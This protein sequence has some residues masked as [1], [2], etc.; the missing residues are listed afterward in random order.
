MVGDGLGQGV[1]GRVRGAAIKFIGSSALTAG[2]DK[3]ENKKISSFLPSLA[4][5]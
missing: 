1:R 2:N 5:W 4:R 3:I